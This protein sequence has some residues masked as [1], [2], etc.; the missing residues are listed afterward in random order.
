[1]EDERYALVYRFVAFGTEPDGREGVIGSFAARDIDE[2]RRMAPE[3]F[4]EVPRRVVPLTECTPDEAFEAGKLDAY[5]EI[6][7]PGG[8]T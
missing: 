7:D 1:M 3:I 4:D 2:A 5:A 8:D 6:D